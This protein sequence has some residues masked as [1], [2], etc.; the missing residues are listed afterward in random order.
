ME[1]VQYFTD[2]ATEDYSWGLLFQRPNAKSG[3]SGF[4]F[5]TQWTRL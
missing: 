3:V 2:E 5:G 4:G 1:T